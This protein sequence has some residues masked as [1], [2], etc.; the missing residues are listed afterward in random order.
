[1][2]ESEGRCA[3]QYS[4]LSIIFDVNP[5]STSIENRSPH[6]GVP[7]TVAGPWM[8]AGRRA[9]RIIADGAAR[10]VVTAAGYLA[11]CAARQ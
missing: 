4:T 7:G 5:D 9:W 8:I 11:E 3:T 10:S 1:M 2:I 6:S